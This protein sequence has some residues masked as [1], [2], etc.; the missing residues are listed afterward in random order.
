VRA[1]A[2]K[3]P[4]NG[5]LKKPSKAMLTRKHLLTQYN[6]RRALS[7]LIISALPIFSVSQKALV[8]LLCVL[9]FI[10]CTDK[11]QKKFGSRGVEALTLKAIW[12]APTIAFTLLASRNA[13]ND[14]NTGLIVGY[15]EL[16][17]S[18]TRASLYT[19]APLSL[20]LASR[21]LCIRL[22][23][24]GQAILAGLQLK[25]STCLLLTPL[26]T[27]EVARKGYILQFPTL[28]KF[29]TTWTGTYFLLSAALGCFLLSQ[30]S[31]KKKERLI[32]L[33]LIT[34]SILQ[35][36]YSAAA[37]NN[38][39]CTVAGSILLAVVLQTRLLDNASGKNKVFKKQTMPGQAPFNQLPSISAWLAGI[40]AISGL[41][42]GSKVV[43]NTLLKTL[44]IE[45]LWTRNDRL[46][47][48]V[49]GFKRLFTHPF[50]LDY[51]ISGP[52]YFQRPICFKDAEVTFTYG[53]S[54]HNYWHSILWDSLRNSGYFGL[55]LSLIIVVCMVICLYK[56]SRE[57]KRLLALAIGCCLLIV[58]TTPIVEVGA[59]EI[60][61]LTLTF[62]IL[63]SSNSKAYSELSNRESI[64][65]L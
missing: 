36:F 25:I 44:R 17:S 61:P 32:S 51:L 57:G 54:C 28:E 62:M 43:L 16:A 6:W 41:V 47:F 42:I 48:F 9:V 19:I 11:N 26:L 3:R 7:L 56:Y 58:F 45:H 29:V 33:T 18:L 39:T 20:V 46:E 27:G 31:S 24:I 15:S 4:I 52:P 14:I 10:A 60:L 21:R 30:Q 55:G 50:R 34:A 40:I 2:F 23:T 8:P 63:S 5:A 65:S 1:G 38:L 49:Q 37:L 59:G 12:I 13:F 35:A 22:T 64:Q 53:D